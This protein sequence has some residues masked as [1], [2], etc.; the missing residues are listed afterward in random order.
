MLCSLQASSAPNARRHLQS[1]RLAGN[2]SAANSS[3]SNGALW[4]VRH[5]RCD[6]N[7]G[8]ECECEYSHNRNCITDGRG[9]YNNGDSCLIDVLQ[10]FEISV[11]SYHLE[12]SYDY[13]KIIHKRRTTG[14]YAH[15]YPRGP[16]GVYVEAGD[17][18]EVRSA[19]ER[20]CERPHPLPWNASSSSPAL[21]STADATSP[22]PPLQFVS[23]G[24][25][26]NQGWEICADYPIE[27]TGGSYVGWTEG[28]SSDGFGFRFYYMLIPAF[29][30]LVVGLPLIKKQQEREAVLRQQALSSV[31]QQGG[32]PQPIA[33]GQATCVPIATAVAVPMG[34][35]VPMA[36]SMVVQGVP[37]GGACAATA[38]AAQGGV[39]TGGIQMAQAVPV[40]AQGG[41]WQMRA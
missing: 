1:T 33:Q 41:F 9:P 34:G 40:E 28:S 20:P 13:L 31:R 22:L 27:W 36:Q 25:T 21:A 7:D 39:G 37:P 2:S 15:E 18:I 38:T 4:S 19:C 5:G 35:S 10:G 26:T 8:S 3:A 30:F 12:T 23:D 11:A 16:D 14:Y 6:D 29:I 24:S 32:A 17:V